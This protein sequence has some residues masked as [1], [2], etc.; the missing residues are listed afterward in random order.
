MTNNADMQKKRMTH[1]ER[2]KI[3]VKLSGLTREKFAEKYGLT[4]HTLKSY[5]DTP[6][7]I[8]LE[9]A[10]KFADN[11]GISL[12]WLYCKTD[13]MCN[14]DMVLCALSKLLKTEYITKKAK[15]NGEVYAYREHTLYINA[16]LF[17]FLQ[18]MQELKGELN[19][20][21]TVTKEEYHARCAMVLKKYNDELKDIFSAD[22]FFK[23]NSFEI[24]YLE[25]KE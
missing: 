12:D 5:L 22:G 25:L 10:I 6:K 17:E 24:D 11:Y 16:H 2:L 20:S 3:V 19:G 23:G 8:P 1:Q 7:Q 9:Y 18:A 4:Y 14:T 15:R 13:L 21:Y